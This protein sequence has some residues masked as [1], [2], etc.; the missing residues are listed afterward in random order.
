MNTTI[1]KEPTAIIEERET[2]L[3]KYKTIKNIDIQIKNTLESLT[4][5]NE[6]AVRTPFPPLNPKKHGYIC[7][8][9]QAKPVK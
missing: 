6:A 3:E 9:I 5:T 1:G 4:S 2:I 7:P 8:T